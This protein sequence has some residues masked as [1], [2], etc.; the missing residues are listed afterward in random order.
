MYEM[1]LYQQ[2]KIWVVLGA[3]F[4]PISAV[5]FGPILKYLAKIS[6]KVSISFGKAF[7]IQLAVAFY[8]W[9]SMIVSIFGSQLIKSSVFWRSING[10][11]S[12]FISKLII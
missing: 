4:L 9:V 3:V 6:I 12:I 8:C 10:V 11:L 1:A 5:M 2:L 7:F